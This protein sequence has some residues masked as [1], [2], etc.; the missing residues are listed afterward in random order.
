MRSFTFVS[1][2]RVVFGPGSSRET[3]GYVRQ[4]GERPLIVTS[5]GMRARG[6]TIDRIANELRL[7]GCAVVIFDRA[8]PEPASALVQEGAALVCEEGC[9]VLVAIG[10]G[11]TLD[12]AKVIAVAATHVLPIDDYVLPE[13]GGSREIMSH[14]LPVLAIPST[15]GTGSE[16]TNSAVIRTGQ[17][18]RKRVFA[19]DWLFPR[20]A[21][22]DPILTESLPADV[23]IACA[24]DALTQCIESFVSRLAS[25]PV[26]AISQMGIQLVLANLPIVLKNPKDELGRSNLAL[27]ALLSG[28]AI[29]NS[30]VGAVHALAMALGSMRPIPHGV[31]CGIFLPHVMAVNA[32]H[33]PGVYGELVPTLSPSVPADTQADVGLVVRT[34]VDVQMQVGFTSQL[35]DFSIGPNEV[36]TLAQLAQNPDLI[37]NPIALSLIQ[38]EEII[39]AALQHGG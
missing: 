12:L 29:A 32:A 36:E 6:S 39:V 16:V 31:A 17:P 23:T 28:V 19:S 7:S 34:I 11:S 26:K 38:L 10:G 4:F 3:S 8:E 21:I 9:D 13:W 30:G 14:T 2:T 25:P 15:A 18:N 1:P 24:M 22:V 27:A 37:G 5:R 35:H 33:S 20:V